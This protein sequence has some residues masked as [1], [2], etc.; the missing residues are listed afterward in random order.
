[1]MPRTSRR[2]APALTSRYRDRASVWQWWREIVELYEGALQLEV[3]AWGGLR[4]RVTLP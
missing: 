1:M 4:A 3:S 2:A